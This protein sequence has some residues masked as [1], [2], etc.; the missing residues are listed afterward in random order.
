M[1]FLIG[2]LLWEGPATRGIQIMRCKA[3]FEDSKTGKT[4]MLQGVE[5]LF[6]FREVDGLGEKKCI[7]LFVGK[8]PI[9]EEAIK[10]EILE[11]CGQ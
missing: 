3:I 8:G 4:L 1:E 5:D 10:K 9:E 7:F 11:K 6:E 2:E